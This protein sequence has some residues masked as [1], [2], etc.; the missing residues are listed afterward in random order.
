MRKDVVRFRGK[1]LQC[2][3]CPQGEKLPRFTGL[4]KVCPYQD[5]PSNCN[6]QMFEPRCDEYRGVTQVARYPTYV[7][8]VP[9]I[10]EDEENLPLPQKS[11]NLIV[12]RIAVPV[13]TG[14]AKCCWDLLNL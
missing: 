8:Y 12:G 1:V 13:F 11:S 14:F 5:R 4:Q 2:N 3:A 6:L 9:N 7:I 10:V